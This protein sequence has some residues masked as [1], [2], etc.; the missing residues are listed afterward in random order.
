MSKETENEKFEVAEVKATTGEVKETSITSTPIVLD[1]EF[2]LELENK[3]SS[4][5]T[6]KKKTSLT[7]SMWNAENIGDSIRGIFL[8]F[9]VLNLDNKSIP[10]VVFKNQEGT[11]AQAGVF[12]LDT[13]KDKPLLTAFEATLIEVQKKQGGKTLKKFSITE[14]G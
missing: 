2:Y 9:Q 14:L 4:L 10:A 1:D 8:G 3:I 13:F 6:L 11:F 5:D 12:F 7:F